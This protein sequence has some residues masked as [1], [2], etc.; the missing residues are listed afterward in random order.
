MRFR[1]LSIIGSIA[2]SLMAASAVAQL[3]MSSS[4]RAKRILERI[5][6]VKVPGDHPLLTQMKAAIDAGDVNGAATLALQHEGFLN[7]TVKQMVLKMS[8]REETI[9]TP[10]ND[11]VATFIGAIRDDLDA[12][13]LLTGNYTYRADPA[14]VPN[15]VTVR[16]NVL[17]DILRSNNHYEDLDSPNI[18]LGAVLTRIDGQQVASILSNAAVANP[19]PAGVLT[20]RAFMGAHADMGTNRRPVEFT[21]REFMCTEITQMSDISM[22]DDRIGRDI[23]RFPGGEHLKFQTSC[24]GCHTQLDG[25]RGAFARWDFINGAIIHSGVENANRNGF[26]N[27]ISNKLNTNNNVFPQG[28]VVTDSTWVNNATGTANAA[29][30]GWRGGMSGDGVKDFAAAIANSKRFSE[31]MAKRVYEEVC[32]PVISIEG[33]KSY[34][35]NLA[36]RFESANYNFKKLFVDVVT[37]KEC[38][39]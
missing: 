36:Q 25:F 14:R 16:S 7:V 35:A 15:G 10:L 13:T 34:I 1:H 23:D 20:S 32:Q 9:R 3:D 11:M 37:S 6:G 4:A 5:S 39:I 24:K 27:G 12:R 17:N 26:S 18:D 29:R 22:P 2:F 21:F 30:F 19:D 38:G 8:T 31:C 28:Y 33:N